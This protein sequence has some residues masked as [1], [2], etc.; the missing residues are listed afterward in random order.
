MQEQADPG[1]GLP[2]VWDAGLLAIPAM[3]SFVSLLFVYWLLPNIEVR[4]RYIWPGALVA[5]LGL[6]LAKHGFAF[7]LGN[8]ATYSVVYGSLWGVI[9]LLTWVYLSA[10]LLL[11]GAEV[12]A[13]VPHVL[14][15]EPRHGREGATELHWRR[16]LVSALRGLVLAPEREDEPLRGAQARHGD[17][18]ES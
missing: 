2:W 14:H 7:Y 6:E 5:A 18:S 1:G 12:A 13:E 8:F 4:V 3:L 17:A 11:F 10:N 9:A 16:A 15:E